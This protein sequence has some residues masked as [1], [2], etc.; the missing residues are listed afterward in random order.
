MMK[1][2][3]RKPLALHTETVRI[4]TAADMF[5]IRGGQTNLTWTCSQYARCTGCG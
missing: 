1:K 3:N 2:I 4:L 5:K